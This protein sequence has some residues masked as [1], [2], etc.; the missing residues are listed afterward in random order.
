MRWPEGPPHLALNPLYLFCFH[1]FSLSFFLKRKPVFPLKRGIFGLLSVSP[2]FLPSFLFH[3]PFSLSLSLSLLF[4]F[5]L[6][7]FLLFFLFCFIFLPCF[8]L[9]VSLPSFFAF[10]ALK[11]QHQNIKSESFYLQSFLLFLVSC[12]V[13]SLKSLFLI[14]FFLILSLVFVQHQCFL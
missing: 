2:L 8:C 11:E 4:L 9:F 13:L 6:P 5:F 14:L 3:F 12:F 10:V 1:F 7:S